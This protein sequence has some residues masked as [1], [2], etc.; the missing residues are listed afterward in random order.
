MNVSFK[1]RSIEAVKQ[2]LKGLPRGTMIPALRALVEFIVGN[3]AHGLRHAEPYKFA[4]R[5]RAYGYVSQDGAPAGYFS[6]KQFCYVA[7]KTK[8]FTDMGNKRT[9]AGVAA[10][11]Y[12]AQRGGYEFKISNDNVGQLFARHE[13]R[14]ARQLAN[15]GWRKIGQVIADNIA[16]AMRMANVAVKRVLAGK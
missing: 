1:I 3:A 13:Q 7:A 10:W 5:A 16:G 14:Q 2:Y 15:V 11:Q 8:G 6:M 4:S 12:T 9:G